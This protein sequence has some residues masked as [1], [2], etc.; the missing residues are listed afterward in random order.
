MTYHLN[1][2]QALEE[3]LDYCVSLNTRDIRAD[4][5]IAEMT[6]DHP[7]Y[8]FDTIE[9]QRRVEALQGRR[10]TFFAGAHLGYGFHEDGLQS[11]VRVAR[12]FGIE[13]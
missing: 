8:T 13:L 4:T 5:L 2:L 10:H 1:R 9:A 11:G 12:R 3:P 6:Y 7:S